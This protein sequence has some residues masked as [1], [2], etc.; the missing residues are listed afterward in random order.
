MR[1]D[2]LRKRILVTGGAGF[3]GS[4]LCERLLAEGHD[5]LCADNFFTGTKDNIAHL[6]P[7]PHFEPIDTCASQSRSRVA[8]CVGRSF[9]APENPAM[10][11][12]QLDDGLPRAI[13]Y[14]PQLAA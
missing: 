9:S 8:R 5:V 1:N 14:F 11:G 3:L 10:P 6:Q 13:D 12:V 4:H 7:N 2:N